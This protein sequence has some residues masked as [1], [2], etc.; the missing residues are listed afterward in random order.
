[1]RTIDTT[2]LDI[3]ECL[4]VNVRVVKHRFGGNTTDIQ[5]RPAKTPT[6]LYT[7]SLGEKAWIK[8]GSEKGRR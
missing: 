2:F 5:A 6:L 3:V 1:M 7:C 4:V 8:F